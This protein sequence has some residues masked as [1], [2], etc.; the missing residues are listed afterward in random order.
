MFTNADRLGGA[1]VLLISE[2][3]SRMFFPAGDAIGQR[4]RFG[5]RGGY[6]ENKG[7]I[8]GIVGDVHHFGLDAPAP[9]MFYLPLAQAGLDG[10]AAVI[11]TAGLLGTLGQSARKAI[12][13]ID[14]D[15]LVGEMIPLETMVSGSL[16]Q[17]R[18]YMML[19]GAFAGLALVLAAV[20]LY[21]VISYTVAQKT[22][23]IGIRV[24]L[25]AARK[26]VLSMIMRQ[27]LG[28][29]AI[30]LAVGQV[31][32]IMLSRALNGLL[33]GVST[34]DPLT[35]GATA[36]VLLIVAVLAC[37]VPARRATRVDPM[38]ALRFE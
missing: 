19:L 36:A 35:L 25:G 18:F 29:A 3:A 28:F 32:T 8:V 7:E 23:E 34:T 4:L 22:H 10:A 21:G 5:A 14:R 31:M 30:G 33:V 13:S 16:G 38:V 15:A 24:A 12:Q 1:R 37:Y 20:G 27:G 2:T 17:R 6:E 26:E 9:P 11:R